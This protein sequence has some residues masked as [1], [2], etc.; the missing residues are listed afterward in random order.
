MALLLMLFQFLSPAFIPLIVQATPTNKAITYNVQH[1]SIVAPM[2]LKE[3]DEKEDC[4]FLPV[5][6]S[7]PLLDLTSH[8]SNLTASHK[9][10]YSISFECHTFLQP[11][12]ST[13]YC[14]FLI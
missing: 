10:K 9:E 13:L 4:D 12:L 5:S 8:S 1:S 7:T 6:D 11:P 14:T 2:L 3:K